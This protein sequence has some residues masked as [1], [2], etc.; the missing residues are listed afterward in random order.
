MLHLAGQLLKILSAMHG[1]VNIKLC[2]FCTDR[3]LPS[4]FYLLSSQFRP[5]CSAVDPRNSDQV[6]SHPPSF[7]F[8][9]RFLSQCLLHAC[10]CRRFGDATSNVY[11]LSCGERGVEEGRSS[12]RWIGI[13]RV[14][15][16]ITLYF[17]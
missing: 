4:I 8:P 15:T 3:L 13:F 16:R 7:L 10:V 9:L 5:R 17:L 6:G 11:L 2:E 12:A 1:T 14:T